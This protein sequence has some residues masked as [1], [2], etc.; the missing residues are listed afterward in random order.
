MPHFYPQR[1]GTSTGP[2]HWQSQ[3]H[4]FPAPFA[5]ATL[6]TTRSAPFAIVTR[7]DGAPKPNHNSIQVVLV[8]LLHLGRRIGT[9][10]H[11]GLRFDS[12]FLGLGEIGVGVGFIA[13]LPVRMTPLVVRLGQRR[14]ESNGHRVVADRFV[15][16]A[17]LVV[18]QPRL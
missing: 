16:V 1:D 6:P 15:V 11:A 17:F 7:P 2:S 18:G 10:R 12:Q 13:F 8:P 3:W 4:T 14:V 9:T 5:S